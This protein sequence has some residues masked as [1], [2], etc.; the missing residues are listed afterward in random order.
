[1]LLQCGSLV[2]TRVVPVDQLH[3]ASV[4]AVPQRR[5]APEVCTTA[6]DKNYGLQ[7]AKSLA[8]A[9]AKMPPK[10]KNSR[11]KT[12]PVART[13]YDGG[14]SGPRRFVLPQRPVWTG[15]DGHR[16]G[17]RRHDHDNDFVTIRLQTS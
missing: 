16:A 8:R 2:T 7:Q 6:A 4:G 3:G 11:T 13:L 10:G 1:M 9:R 5:T 12:G 15:G 14:P 17:P